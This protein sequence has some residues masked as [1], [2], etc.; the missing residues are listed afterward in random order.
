MDNL[1]ILIHLLYKKV[2]SQQVLENQIRYDSFEKAEFLSLASSYVFYYS[3]NELSNLLEYYIGSLRENAKT[4]GR[5]L[6]GGLNVFEALYY[7]AERFLIVKNSEVMCRYSKLLN[8]RK[9]AL[10]LDE[11]MYVAAFLASR[12]ADSEMQ[13]LGFCW[14]RVI[15]HD[16]EQLSTIVRRGVS[17]NHFHLNGS[18]PIFH[19]SWLGLMNNINSSRFMERLQTYDKNRRYTNAIYTDNYREISFYNRAVQ[20]A[21]IRV[22]IFSKLSGRRMKIGGYYEKMSFISGYLD[23]SLI[24]IDG[25][26]IIL[27]SETVT[28]LIC[29]LQKIEMKKGEY[30]YREIV[31]FISQKIYKD[32]EDTFWGN[33]RDFYYLLKDNIGKCRVELTQIKTC[34]RESV[35]RDISGLF[36]NILTR[37][38]RVNLED[39]KSFFIDMREFYE[40]W[41]ERTLKNVQLLLINPEELSYH[42]D[43]IQS[44]IDSYKM[45]ILTVGQESAVDY[46][47]QELPATWKEESGNFVFSGERRFMY[48]MFKNVY[49]QEPAYSE[50]YNLFY[51]YLLIKESIRSEMIQTNKNVGFRNF[52]RYQD[53]KEDFLLDDIYRSAFIRTAVSESLVTDNVE[54]IELRMRPWAS[55]EQNRE[56]ILSTD[57]L[58][59]PEDCLKNRFFYTLH[60]LKS[61]DKAEEDLDFFYCRHYKMRKRIERQAYAI[62]ELRERYP[63]VGRRILGIDAASN[64]IGCR[65]E[66][67]AVIFRYLRNH[68]ACY[69]APN[70]MYKLPQLHVTYHVG[71]DFLD[72]VDGLRAIEEAVVFLGMESGDRMGHALALGVDVKDWYETKKYRIALPAQD[73]LDNLVWVYHKLI[74]YDLKGFENLKEWIMGEFTVLFYDIYIANTTHSELVCIQ[75][76]SGRSESL[77]IDE[78]NVNIFNYYYAWQL[79]GD[80]P[81]LYE[82]GFFDERKYHKDRMEYQVN[83]E[84]PKRYGLRNSLSIAM[85]YYLYHY[86]KNVRLQ[87]RR[88]K[89]ICISKAYVRAVS[90]IQKCMQKEIAKKGI[91]IETNP[92]SNYLI[93]TFRQYEKHP[94]IQ[95][96]NK[97]LVHDSEKIK[98]CPQIM[99]SINT[100]DQGVFHTSLENEYALLAC[101]LE[102]VTDEDDRALYSKGDIYDWLDRIRIMGNEQSFGYLAEKKNTGLYYEKKKDGFS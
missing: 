80:A 30:T 52:Q 65:P 71:E 94:I 93:G 101:A 66:V 13:K 79:R 91:A 95:W 99:V 48:T 86:N 35:G 64:E 89:E 77:Q 9:V 6:A 55:A 102:N 58:L 50:Y 36:I 23:F 49:L 2:S 46:M 37:V 28:Q 82:T 75:E 22:L 97:G 20:A 24:P 70:G 78:P 32:A 87:G 43:A 39:V 11:D 21:L 63:I 85:I 19:V 72:V 15:N 51:A 40:I 98:E 16:N 76:R 17:E 41:D 67:F 59:D 14:K 38:S 10:E 100:D 61:Q 8:W 96:Y 18:A 44:I 74:E 33:N 92:S 27:G 57:A 84:Y 12:F 54:K 53:R 42:T 68:R 62:A 29:E 26:G 4:K 88:N 60:F 1:E 45:S 5:W 34:L 7:S 69:M 31:Q 81:E 56:M 73:Y 83:H 25:M 47:L 3:E 90:E